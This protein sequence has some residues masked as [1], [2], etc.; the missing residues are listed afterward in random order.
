MTIAEGGTFGLS[1]TTIFP[2]PFAVAPSSFPSSS[3]VP[4]SPPT[5]N[6]S[7]SPSLSL[8]PT[9]TCYWLEVSIMTDAYPFE[10]NWNV[11]QIF[12]VDGIQE[13]TPPILVY[14]G[15]IVTID[16]EVNGISFSGTHIDNSAIDSHVSGVICACGLGITQCNCRGKV[17]LIEC[18]GSMFDE[19]V[20]NC[21]LGGGLAAVIYNNGGETHL[22]YTL[23]SKP[24]S[25]PAIFISQTDGRY[26]LQNG[27]GKVALVTSSPSRLLDANILNSHRLC[28]KKGQYAFNI[29]DRGGDGICCYYGEGRYNVMSGGKLLAHGGEFGSNECTMFSVPYISSDQVP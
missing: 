27:I 7:L 9:E 3:H 8:S 15:G 4:S 28:L 24:A 25:I 19:K 17:C 18:G 11:S 16:F 21:E 22:H 12:A 5:V 1:E 20:S 10:T 13:M 6:P 14:C 23:G 29:H 2:I 26:L